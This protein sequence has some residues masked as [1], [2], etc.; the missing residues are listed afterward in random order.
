MSNLARIILCVGALHLVVLSVLHEVSRTELDQHLAMKRPEQNGTSQK[1]TRIATRSR[2][3]QS[4]PNSSALIDIP[5]IYSDGLPASFNIA[6]VIPNPRSNLA[7]RQV[8][9]RPQQRM[10]RS[11]AQRRKQMQKRY[12]ASR[13]RAASQW[14]R[15]ERRLAYSSPALSAYNQP[16]VISQSA[17]Y[18]PRQRVSRVKALGIKIKGFF[19]RI[20][21]KVL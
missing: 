16:R 17:T 10:F 18:S 4:T 8:A 12:I 3:N 5:H 2:I 6:A 13:P 19:S 7:A 1:N 11:T 15:Q 21:Q 20:K 14:R 9:S